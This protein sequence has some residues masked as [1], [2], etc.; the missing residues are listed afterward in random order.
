MATLVAFS[1]LQLLDLLTTLAFLAGGVGEANPVVRLAFLVA[2]TPLEALVGLKLLALVLALYCFSRGRLRLL[3]GANI[4]YA[5][6][7]AWNLLALL[8]RTAAV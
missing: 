3:E 2:P 8:L 1:Y 7:V 5:G 4:F 6:L